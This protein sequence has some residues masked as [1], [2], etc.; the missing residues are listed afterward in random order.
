MT[1]LPIFLTILFGV[2][3]VVFTF[4]VFESLR[5]RLIFPMVISGILAVFFYLMCY[6]WLLQVTR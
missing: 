2:M 1:S 4:F 3:N 5:E 6:G